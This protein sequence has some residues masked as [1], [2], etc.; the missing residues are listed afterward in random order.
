MESV[1]LLHEQ[2]KGCGAVP[3]RKASPS[4]D[5]IFMTFKI[6]PA[7]QALGLAQRIFWDSFL[8]ERQASLLGSQ[9]KKRLSTKA[10]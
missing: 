7:L 1:R 3:R 2:R 6:P 9:P 10:L 4:R 8:S 5:K